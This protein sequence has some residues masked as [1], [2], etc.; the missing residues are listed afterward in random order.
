MPDVHTPFVAPADS[1]AANVVAAGTSARMQVL[2]GPDQGAPNFVLRRFIMGAG[3]G[4]PFH[5]NE[6]EH[7]QYVL[8]GRARIRIGDD[9]HE[10]KPD[11]TLYIPAGVPHSYE[12]LEAPFEFLCVVPNAP[13]RIRLAEGC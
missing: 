5:T 7:E 1:A 8:R 4:M 3:G 11:T 12:V 9:V 6:V 10:V 13:D 2:V